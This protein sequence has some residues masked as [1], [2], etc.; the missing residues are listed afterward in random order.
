VLLA[1]A[2]ND[3]TRHTISHALRALTEQAARRPD[4]PFSISSI[5]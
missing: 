4:Q 5:R 2:G 3:T 1:V